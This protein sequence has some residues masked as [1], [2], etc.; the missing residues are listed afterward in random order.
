MKSIDGSPRPPAG[1]E[2]DEAI[3]QSGDGAA[4][5]HPDAQPIRPA[6]VCSSRSDALQRVFAFLAYARVCSK[7]ASHD[8]ADEE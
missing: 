8:G 7:G 5:F 6:E 4:A 3:P 1:T 2:K